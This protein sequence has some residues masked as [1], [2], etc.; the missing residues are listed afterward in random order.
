MRK[1]ELTQDQEF[2][3]YGQHLKPSEGSC[4]FNLTQAFLNNTLFVPSKMN[5]QDKNQSISLPVRKLNVPEGSIIGKCLK[6]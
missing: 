3:F 1:L 4:S 6:L 2:N 5:S